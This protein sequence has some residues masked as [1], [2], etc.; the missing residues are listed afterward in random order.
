MLQQTQVARVVPRYE[1][2]LERWPSAAALAA[3]PLA[4]VLAAWVGLGY[5]RR[6]VRLW[7]ACRIVAASGWPEDL[8]V[9]PG[10]GPY[11]ADAVRAFAFGDAGARGVLPGV[12]PP[13]ADAVGAFALE[14]P[15]VPRDTNVRRV[16]AR[17]G[18]SLTGP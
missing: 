14:E 1:A 18:R 16:Y 15:V 12:G 13:P 8:G 6:A 2:W 17:L 7:E 4:D 5:N 11:T 3:A 10:V 9:L